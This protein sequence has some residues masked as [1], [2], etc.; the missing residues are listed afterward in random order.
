VLDSVEN[1]VDERMS[2]VSDISNPTPVA[3]EVL[4][5]MKNLS[6]NPPRLKKRNGKKG[7]K[8]NPNWIDNL[9]K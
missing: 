6:Q 4:T 9:P 7:S 8:R 1:Q 5:F 2:N 3:D